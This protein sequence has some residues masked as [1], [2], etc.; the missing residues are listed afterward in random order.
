MGLKRATVAVAFLTFCFGWVLSSSARAQEYRFSVPEMEVVL[1]VEPDASVLVE[2]HM[3]FQNQP[4]AHAIDVV[5]M[6]MPTKDYEVLGASIDGKPLHS[7]RPSTYIETGPEVHLEPFAIPAGSAGVFECRARVRDMVYEDR[8]D[9]QRAS[10]RFTPTWFGDRY[11]VGDTDLLLTVKFPPGV[12]PDSVVWHSD[13]RKFFQKGILHPD[14]V[15][16]VAWKERYRLTGPMMFGCSFPR[17][18]MQRVVKSSL[19]K[20]FLLWWQNSKGAQ[21]VSGVLYLIL[22]TCCFLLLTRGTGFTLLGV[23]TGGFI[24]VMV[25]SPILHLCLWPLIPMMGGAWYLFMER[26]KPHY[27]PA[28]ARVEGGKIC[29]GLT[30][31]EAAVLLELPLHR[32]LGMVVTDMVSKGVIRLTEAEP[33]QVEPVGTRSAPNVVELPDGRKVSLEPYEVGFLDVL[34]APPKEMDEKDFSEPLERLVGFVRYKMAGFDA[35]ATRQYYRSI[36][37]RA[38]DQVSG[39]EDPKRKDDLANRHLNW[40]SMADDYDDRMETQREQG[41]YYIP[42][43]YYWSGAGRRRDW[44]GD[45]NRWVTPAAERS[46]RGIVVPAKGLDLRG[47]DHFTLDALKELAR[48]AASGGSGCAGGGCA[49]ACAGCACAC[50][51][52]GGGR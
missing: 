29:R 15:A 48:S 36:T 12:Q 27:M 51:C 25:T 44:V 52:A 50:A 3:K 16:F 7:W 34:S 1:T 13:E 28:L 23:F 11:V 47:V 37:E 4:G 39:E 49:C 10:L 14:N 45:I 2:Y 5:D 19:W 9:S 33:P 41:W 43:W 17:A 8:T 30:S 6:G 26:R 18:V 20:M 24:I 35:D 32:V 21:Q 42:R 38:W 40:L 22:F 46:S 31:A